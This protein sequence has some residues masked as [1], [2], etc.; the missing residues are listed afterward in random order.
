MDNFPFLRL[1][2]QEI[3][4]LFRVYRIVLGQT[5]EQRDQI[6]KHLS[7]LDRV[8]FEEFLNGIVN[9]SKQNSYE[10]VIL[11]AVESDEGI[12]VCP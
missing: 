1:T 9:K 2:E 4:D 10:L 12:L 7:K 5:I 3:Y 11:N 6:I 8:T